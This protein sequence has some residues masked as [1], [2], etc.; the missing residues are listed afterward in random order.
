VEQDSGPGGLGTVE[1]V[2]PGP[3][4]IG[5]AQGRGG[6]LPHGAGVRQSPLVR[7]TPATSVSSVALMN[8]TA[9]STR[10]DELSGRDFLGKLY[11]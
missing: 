8:E 2:E 4:V 1:L 11:T 6:S 3:A 10:S 5:G 9:L 7:C